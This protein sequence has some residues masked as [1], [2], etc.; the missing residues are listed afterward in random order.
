MDL[1]LHGRLAV[2]MG[3]T[4][5]IG[6]ATADVLAREGCEVELAARDPRALADAC[7]LV[8]RHGHSVGSRALDVRDRDAVA[9][10]LD[11]LARER[12][13]GVL[14][15]SVS[16]QSLSWSETVA[17]D[18]LGVVNVVDAAREHLVAARGAL[19]GVASQAGSLAAPGHKAY[20]AGKAA[21]ISY[22]ASLAVELAPAGVRVNAV[23]PGEVDFPGGFWDRMREQQP[24]LREST[25]AR[26][27]M[28]RFATP[29]EVAAVVAFLASPVA[30]HVAGANV[31]VDGAGR[32]HVQ[33]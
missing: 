11:D 25:L 5:G 26:K 27:P 31:L 7:R 14:V 13:L 6:L 23:S 2:V 32:D 19:V 12:P 8:G 16:A 15:W 24:S 28:G 29:E 17:T 1:Q 20:A 4:R 22:L 33:F 3:A 30:G 18:L 9:G 10:W 21:L